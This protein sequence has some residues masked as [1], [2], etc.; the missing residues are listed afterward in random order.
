MIKAATAIASLHTLKRCI[1]ICAL[2]NCCGGTSQVVSTEE[3][4][5]TVNLESF[6]ASC[7]SKRKVQNMLQPMSQ[8]A[9]MQERALTNCAARHPVSERDAPQQLLSSHHSFDCVQTVRILHCE[10]QV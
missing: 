4:L 7:S 10:S 9:N 8:T 1:Y 6:A 5:V 2:L 3:T